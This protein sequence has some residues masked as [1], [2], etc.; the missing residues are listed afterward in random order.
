MLDVLLAKPAE[1]RPIQLDGVHGLSVVHEGRDGEE[2]GRVVHGVPLDGVGEVGA[3]H[4]TGNLDRF[5]FLERDGCRTQLAELLLPW[6]AD[7]QLP[8][9]GESEVHRVQVLEQRPH[10]VG[11]VRECVGF[12]VIGPTVHGYGA[13]QLREHVGPCARR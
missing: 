4:R 11:V 5:P 12:D 6:V 13:A 10:E 8:L 3:V 1:D 2:R 7:L 9:V